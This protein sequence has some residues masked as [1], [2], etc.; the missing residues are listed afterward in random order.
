MTAISKS[1]LVDTSFFI[2]LW[3]S[4]DNCHEEAKSKQGYFDRYRLVVPWPVLYETLN[5]RLLKNPA[6]MAGFEK[7]ARRLET[8][9]DGPYR[10]GALRAVREAA[11]RKR[12]P[13]DPMPSLVD[14]IILAMIDDR[15]RPF[16]GIL[17]FNHRDFMKPCMSR[18]IEYI[19]SH[20]GAAAGYDPASAAPAGPRAR[21]RSRKKT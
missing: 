10:R 2:A 14:R 12:R 6:R 15:S 19:C 9:D 20:P 5:T 17:T 8:I 21:R 13:E 4:R 18:Q 16:H 3:D 11:R 7:A 1:I